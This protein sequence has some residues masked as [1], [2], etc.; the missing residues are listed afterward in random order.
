LGSFAF[1]CHFTGSDEFFFNVAILLNGHLLQRVLFTFQLAQLRFPVAARDKE[2]GWPKQ[3]QTNKASSHDGSF[4]RACG[5]WF[6]MF[7]DRVKGLLEH[8]RALQR[9]QRTRMDRKSFLID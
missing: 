5:A 2:Q 8:L 1:L 6:L 4:Y 7:S 3:D 9:F